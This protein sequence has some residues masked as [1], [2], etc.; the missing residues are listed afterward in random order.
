MSTSLGA[1]YRPEGGTL[2]IGAA[3]RGPAATRTGRT[4]GWQSSCVH[5]REPVGCIVIDPFVGSG[6]VPY[7]A[8]KHGRHAIGIDL[9]ASYLELA[10]RRLQQLSLFA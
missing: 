9:S 8:R 1:W 4:T 5:D 6:T 2:E 7:V 10:A 3:K